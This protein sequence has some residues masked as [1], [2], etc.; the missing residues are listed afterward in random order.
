M[1]SPHVNVLLVI[2]EDA[3]KGKCLWSNER[4][5]LPF[6]MQVKLG[7]AKLVTEVIGIPLSTARKHASVAFQHLFNHLWLNGIC[8][9]VWEKQ[10]LNQCHPYQ[11]VNVW[12]H[13]WRIYKYKQ[14]CL[15]YLCMKLAPFSCINVSLL[16]CERK[17]PSYCQQGWDLFLKVLN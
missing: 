12:R 1:D 13:F 14:W 5:N 9:L 17:V 11:S 16:Y 4:V 15:K 3:V 6:S 7:L 8:P 2:L 10:A